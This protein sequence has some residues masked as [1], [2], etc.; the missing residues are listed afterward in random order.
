MKPSSRLAVLLFASSAALLA[1]SCAHAPVGTDKAEAESGP[2]RQLTEDE[3]RSRNRQVTQVRYSLFF[4]VDGEHEDFE[5]RVVVSFFWRGRNGSQHPLFMDFHEGKIQSLVINGKSVADAGRAALY[6]GTRLQLPESE[7]V[8]GTNRVEVAFTHP[9]G[10][11]GVGL[12]RFV[13]PEDKRVYLY[14]QAEPFD[15]NRIFPCFDQPDLKASFELTVEAP[16]DWAV[17]S[18]MAEKDV[19]IFD[20]KSS[21]QFPPSP[22][23]S[24][25]LFALHAGPFAAWKSDAE[26]IPLRLF[27]RES[28]RRHVDSSEW[29]E[30]TRAGF[31]YFNEWFATPYP[32]AKYDQVIVPEFAS[33]A[34]ENVGA[35]TFSEDYLFRSRAT[36]GHRRER[37]DTILHEMAHMWFGNLVTMR[38]WDG[39]WLNES[40]A[41]YAAWRAL[42]EIARKHPRLAYTSWAQA[43]KKDSGREL[44]EQKLWAYAE[45]SSRNTHPI[46][47]EAPDT[48]ASET[49]FDGI[50]YAKGAAVLKQLVAWIGEE[51][52]TEGLRRYFALN[53]FRSATTSQF[54]RSMEEASGQ[55]L[56]EWRRQWLQSAG[57]NRLEARWD[58]DPATRKLTSF[59]LLQTQMPQST[60]LRRHQTRIGLGYGTGLR[61]PQKDIALSIKYSGAVNPVPALIGTACPDFVQPNDGDDDY[62]QVFL[63]ARSRQY[64]RKNLA[65]V[66]S[67]LLREQ[68][69]ASLWHA[70]VAGEM[71][72]AE[73]AEWF[74]DQG[75]SEKD[76]K[77]LSSLIGR[78]AS[79][80]PRRGSV[81]HWLATPAQRSAL[82]ARLG[83]EARG[84]LY[85]APAGGD[86]QQAWWQVA[87]LHAIQSGD[88][89]WLEKVLQSKARIPGIRID[90]ERRWELLHALA[91][92]GRPELQGRMEALL[93]AELKRDPSDEGIKQALAVR[94]ARATASSKEE[95]FARATS[96][97]FNVAEL[98]EIGSS[99]QLLGQETLVAPLLDRYIAAV[100]EIARTRSHEEATL[101]V[102]QFYPASCSEQGVRTLRGLLSSGAGKFPLGVIQALT[103]LEEEESRCIRLRVQPPSAQSVT[104]STTGQ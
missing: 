76:P 42:E 3:A 57:A 65:R 16:Q 104:S 40:F 28:L 35:V 99:F 64:L 49:A 63:D 94:S 44:F 96:G 93:E 8:A 31:Q 10:R 18:N 74:F 61:A 86:L 83:T 79:S 45:D 39:L 30:L 67:P 37:A 98:E 19:A 89:D 54:L 100:P 22:V 69:W 91:Q 90:Q 70:V 6:D 20:Q 73:F 4:G 27:A 48:A 80:S 55:P 53:S 47:M 21:W 68:L 32:F 51:D 102:A 38:W 77:I 82:L 50:T 34:M 7:L 9:Y 12:H 56:G 66:Q 24:T 92:L 26:G 87:L 15:A 72:P 78:M 23:F 52:F 85:R 5:G 2:R 36:D 46:E 81:Q 59:E 29:F 41:T 11:D 62:A 17:V 1:G 103:R 71:A 33:G 95:A 75:A 60:T 14:S 13:D 97:K 84:M 25:Y 101:F 43:L 88:S 58:C